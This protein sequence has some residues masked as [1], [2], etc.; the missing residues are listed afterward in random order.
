MQPPS[1][2]VNALAWTSI[3]VSGLSTF[4]SFVQAVLAKVLV[5]G[6]AMDLIRAEA[7]ASQDPAALVAASWIPWMPW[8]FVLMLVLSAISLVASIGLLKRR[9]WAR[10]LFIALL[11]LG[12]VSNVAGFFVQQSVIDMLPTVPPDA[13]APPMEEFLLGFRIVSGVMILALTVLL[14]W[15]AKRLMAPQIVAEFRAG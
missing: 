5:S 14:A 11:V 2:F 9:E 3:V 10:R 15:L 1:S 4:A 6:E 13:G 7:E 12:M 8:V